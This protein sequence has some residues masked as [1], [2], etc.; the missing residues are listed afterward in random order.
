LPKN[1]YPGIAVAQNCPCRTDASASKDATRRRFELRHGLLEAVIPEP[2]TVRCAQYVE[3]LEIKP[4]PEPGSSLCKLLRPTCNRII[5]R[6]M[7]RL[8]SGIANFALR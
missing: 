6:T 2:R 8:V 1:S 4:M 5:A 3:R 7:S